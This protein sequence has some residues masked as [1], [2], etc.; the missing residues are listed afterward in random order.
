MLRE[1]FNLM[2]CHC[3]IWSVPCTVMSCTLLPSASVASPVSLLL[4]PL[5]AGTYTEGFE[6]GALQHFAFH[7]ILPLKYSLLAWFF[8]TPLVFTLTMQLQHFTVPI[9]GTTL[10]THIQCINIPASMKA[11]LDELPYF[12]AGNFWVATVLKRRV[13]L[14]HLLR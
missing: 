1:E 2:K 14:R 7:L 12:F 13:G 11:K 4:S 10:Q 6:L 5:I 3:K 9:V 8:N